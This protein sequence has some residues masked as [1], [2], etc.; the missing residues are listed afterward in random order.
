VDVRSIDKGLHTRI[1]I[2]LADKKECIITELKDDTKDNSH[3]AA[4]L[5][6]Y[7]KSKSIVSSYDSI[8]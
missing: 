7:S 8:F 3:T 6:T 5:S 2:V 1:T 4:G